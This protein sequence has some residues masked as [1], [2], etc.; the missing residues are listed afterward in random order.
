MFS[1]DFREFTKLLI[2]NEAECL[3][4]GGYVLAFM[5]ISDIHAIW[6]FG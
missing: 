3:I 1:Q 4:V 2:K 6:T 5:G